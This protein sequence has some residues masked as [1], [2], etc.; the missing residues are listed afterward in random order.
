[1]VSAWAAVDNGVSLDCASRVDLRASP[2]GS[3]GEAERGRT[4]GEEE[5][6]GSGVKWRV[7]VTSLP[8]RVPPRCTMVAHARQRGNGRAAAGTGNNDN[9][10]VAQF[11][12]VFSMFGPLAA[13]R[14]QGHVRRSGHRA[15]QLLPPWHPAGILV[16]PAPT[17][18]LQHQGWWGQPADV[19]CNGGHSLNRSSSSPVGW[20]PELRECSLVGC[21]TATSRHHEAQSSTND[22]QH[23]HGIARAQHLS[24]TTPDSRDTLRAI[25]LTTTPSG[26][27][28]AVRD[29]PRQCPAQQYVSSLPTPHHGR[30]RG[31]DRA[32]TPTPGPGSRL[33]YTA[34]PGHN[35]SQAQGRRDRTQPAEAQE[36]GLDQVSPPP[37]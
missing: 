8:V 21:A 12:W 13:L 11:P 32:L 5:R 37:R 22:D 27:P 15:I 26:I 23:H 7:A 33:P 35:E 14:D 30:R 19:T 25:L 9:G 6:R 24:A 29:N 2:S 1:M 4:E 36:R 34:V 28:V 10:D 31:Q 17:A 20:L 3:A 18:P 16:L